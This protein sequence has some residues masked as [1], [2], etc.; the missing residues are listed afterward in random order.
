MTEKIKSITGMNDILP[1]EVKLWQKLE[2][3]ARCIFEAYGFEEIRTPIIEDTSLFSRGI[4]TETQVVQ[5]EMYTFAD[6]GGD[7]VTMRPEG[8]AGVVRAYIEHALSAQDEIT[9]LYYMGSMFRYERPQKG[10]LRQFHQIGA[11]L[12]GVDSPQA[13]AEVVIIID[14]LAKA[15]GIREFDVCVNSLGTLDER[16][17][18]LEKLVGYFRAS[19]DALCVDCRNRLEKNPLRLFDCKNERCQGIG[20]QAPLLIDNLSEESK[21]HFGIFQEALT[22][23]GVAFK[24]I[25]RIVRGL[26]YYEKTSFEFVSDRLGSQSAFGGGGRYNRLVEE[27][28]GKPTPGVGFGLGCERMILL[29]QEFLGAEE[30]S[31]LHGVYFIGFNQAGLDK[32][33]ELMQFVRDLGVRAEAGYEPKSMK[34]QMRRANKMGFRFAAIIGDDELASGT[35][36]LKNLSDGAQEAVAFAELA[37]KVAG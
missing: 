7:S 30:K 24:V 10:R 16:K 14:R 23:A 15:V 33:R 18:Y 34:S 19:E 9:K 21:R 29:M 25:P 1:D 27:L 11:E 3:S 31:D 37:K 6:K 17:P 32:G 13:D 36:A 4:G 2:S 8:T 12:L 28:G 35:V 20:A 5:K 26:D 22:K